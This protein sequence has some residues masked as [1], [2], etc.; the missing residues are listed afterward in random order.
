[1]LPEDEASALVQAQYERTSELVRGM[2]EAFHELWT[3]AG[4]TAA[5]KVADGTVYAV[6]EL[7][8]AIRDTFEHIWMTF[9]LLSAEEAEPASFKLLAAPN[10][11]VVTRSN[12]L[13]AITLRYDQITAVLIDDDEPLDDEE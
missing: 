8:E 9:T 3:F 1:M 5:I 4:H 12:A 11:T 6:S 13:G 2:A 7:T 10:G